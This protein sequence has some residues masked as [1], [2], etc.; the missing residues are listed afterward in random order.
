MTDRHECLDSTM[1]DQL[2][3]KARSHNAWTGRAVSDETVRAIYDLAKW[4]PTAANGNPARFVFIRSEQAK[5]RL[6]PHVNPTNVEK[7]R[8]A[9]CTVI[10][11][12][13]T[14]FHELFPKLFPSRDMRS[15]FEGN[16]ALIADTIA[17]SSTLQGAYLM[18][19]A[20]ALGLDCGPMSGFDQ[21]GTD[22]EF[23]PD[24]RWKSN[25]LCNIGYG[26]PEAL[27]PRNPRLDC[28]EAC[29]DL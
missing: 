13:D 3:R 15:V 16:D 5:A 1:L 12:A 20:R 28:E 26:D 23:F 18:M 10:I 29:L 17:R 25:F 19:A 11:A 2:F 14:R 27:F 9:P 7:V 4:G 22:A 6:L 8:Q 24:G 21:A